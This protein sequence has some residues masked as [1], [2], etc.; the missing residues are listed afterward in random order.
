[1]CWYL[2]FPLLDFLFYYTL[3]TVDKFKFELQAE[4]R[5]KRAKDL[6]GLKEIETKDKFTEFQPYRNIG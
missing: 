5:R 6:S 1:M 3:I 4:T 2:L